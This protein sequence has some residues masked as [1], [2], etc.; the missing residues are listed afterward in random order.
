MAVPAFQVACQNLGICNPIIGDDV[1]G[2]HIRQNC[3][4]N[5]YSWID[6]RSVPHQFT[7]LPTQEAVPSRFVKLQ[8][9]S[10]QSF[11][12]VLSILLRKTDVEMLILN[13]VAKGIV[14]SNNPDDQ[15]ALRSAFWQNYT[16]TLFVAMDGS[17]NYDVLLERE[18]TT[19]IAGTVAIT[20][21]RC[22]EKVCEWD[23]NL[24][25]WIDAKLWE[26][27]PPG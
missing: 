14:G 13:Q 11:K 5:T 1:I 23:R 2:D 10:Y 19:Q 25:D 24:D 15:T 20:Y 16:I 7:T 4:P 9:T 12:H 3:Q 8:S 18:K 6:V 27:F 17:Y 22:Y 26:Y 21:S